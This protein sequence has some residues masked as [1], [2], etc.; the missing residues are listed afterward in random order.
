MQLSTVATICG[1]LLVAS[2]VFMTFAWYAHL[3]DLSAKPWWI[4]ALASWGIALFEYLL[5]G[6]GEPH[7]L[8]R[9]V[10]AAAEDHAGGDHARRCSCPSPSST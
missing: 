6:A 2:N 8:H 5:H 1:L 9:A 7:R 4:A 10:A 3:K